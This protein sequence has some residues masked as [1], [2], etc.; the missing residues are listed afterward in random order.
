ML[1]R[2]VA[3]NTAVQIFGKIIGFF[4]SGTLLVIVSEHLGT[5]NM[6][7]YVTII[8]FVGFFRFPI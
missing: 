3:Y 6:G 4:I 1:A 5:Y 2:K 7:N 8:A